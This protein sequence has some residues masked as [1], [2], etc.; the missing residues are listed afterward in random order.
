MN[1]LDPN[2]AILHFRDMFMLDLDLTIDGEEQNMDTDSDDEYV[3]GPVSFRVPS[4]NLRNF[5]NLVVPEASKDTLTGTQTTTAITFNDR[6]Y[7]A[8]LLADY[9]VST[10]DLRDPSTGTKLTTENL[11]ALGS[12]VS[13]AL[14]D[15]LKQVSEA[16]HV[17]K[18]TTTSKTKYFSDMIDVLGLQ[19]LGLC[20]LESLTSLQNF[21]KIILLCTRHWSRVSA[22]F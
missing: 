5:P 2:A 22:D 3:H 15:T 19:L 1:E 6:V 10:R 13:G 20:E 8:N 9:L 16:P 7:D 14:R 12:V 17:P 21:E 11:D 18:S 4:A